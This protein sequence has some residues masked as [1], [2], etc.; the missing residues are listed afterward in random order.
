MSWCLV[1]S[2]M[3][4]RDRPWRRPDRGAAIPYPQVKPLRQAG[5]LKEL[6]STWA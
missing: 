4:I 6:D 2:E 3:C 5:C 1:G